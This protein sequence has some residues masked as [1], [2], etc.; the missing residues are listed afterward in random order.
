MLN[1][2]PEKKMNTE[3]MEFR[4]VLATLAE[5]DPDLDY[6][7]VHADE[8]FVSLDIF[9]CHYIHLENDH[10]P[11][12]KFYLLENEDTITSKCDEPSFV[13]HW[14]GSVWTCRDSSGHPSVPSA[15]LAELC[16]TY[17]R[18]LAEQLA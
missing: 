13:Y 16:L 12:I 1:S 15:K 7:P 4:D 8:G 14:N 17:L 2:E 9:A 11:T 18:E 10:N 3:F 6:T 5:S